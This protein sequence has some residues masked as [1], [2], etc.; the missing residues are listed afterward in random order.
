M[1]PVF[2]IWMSFMMSSFLII[3]VAYAGF[4]SATCPEDATHANNNYRILEIKVADKTTTLKFD[5]AI[6]STHKHPCRQ[7]SDDLNAIDKPPVVVC[8][9]YRSGASD[10]LNCIE[11]SQTGFQ[12]IIKDHEID[13][14]PMEVGEQKVKKSEEVCRALVAKFEAGAE[15]P[16][17]WAVK[18]ASGMFEKLK[19][20]AAQAF[21]SKQKVSDQIEKEIIAQVLRTKASASRSG[22]R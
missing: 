2:Y 8:S 15:V 4:L 13:D 14:L 5:R 1:V 11:F 17:E 19:D 6:A 20:L 18:V 16:A 7:K 21:G 22:A 12:E 3:P 9:C 10:Y